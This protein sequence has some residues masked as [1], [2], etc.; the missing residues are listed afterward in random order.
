LEPCRRDLSLELAHP[1]PQAPLVPHRPAL[2]GRPLAGRRGPEPGDFGAQR[3]PAP[4]G[5][6]RE[7]VPGPEVKATPSL[8][9]DPALSPQTSPYSRCV[10]ANIQWP[11]RYTM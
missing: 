1:R 6:G 5:G 9:E 2:R 4:P 11:G 10:P 7:T 3:P 8:P